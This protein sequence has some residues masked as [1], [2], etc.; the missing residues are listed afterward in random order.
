MR[1]ALLPVLAGVLLTGWLMTG[2]REI[3]IDGRGVYERFGKPVAVLGPGLHAGLPW[4]FGRLRAVEHGSIHA[5]STV[6]EDDEAPDTSSADGPAPDSAN[7]LWDA[8]HESENGQVIASLAG[9]RQSFQVINMDVRFVYRIAASDTAALAAT[10][11]SADLPSLIRSA[12]GRVLVEDFASRTLDGVLS[13]KRDALAR[14]VGRRVQAELDALDS[15]VEILTTLIEQIHPPSG[16]ANAYHGVQAALIRAQAAIARER[17]RAAEESNEAQLQ[18]AIAID[19]ASAGGREAMAG[20]EAAQLRFA[21]EHSA[22]KAAGQAFV[23]EQYLGQLGT[24]LKD[25]KL[26]LLDHRIGSGTSAPTLDLRR[27]APPADIAAP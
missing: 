21:A 20:A 26:V 13:E 4:P 25:T 1:R 22:F 19:K 6:I 11:H 3:A 23:L 5:I 8:A 10:Y 12:A 24:G 16:A 7:R 27:Y 15:G 9:D 17:G 18:A 2:V 14:D